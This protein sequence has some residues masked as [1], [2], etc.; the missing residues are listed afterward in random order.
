MPQG[1]E[2]G[3]KLNHGATGAEGVTGKSDLGL[4]QWWHLVNKRS[5]RTLVPWGYLQTL[6]PSGVE[7]GTLRRHYYV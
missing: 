7:S 4:G 1:F 2:V 5:S 6:H 3:R